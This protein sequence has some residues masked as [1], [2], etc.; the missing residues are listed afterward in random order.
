[1]VT[2]PFLR[3]RLVQCVVALELLE[4]P[5]PELARHVRRYA[6]TLGVD[7]PMVNAAPARRR[8]PARADVRRHPAQLL[9]HRGG[10]A[11]SPPRPLL[12]AAALEVRVQQP[13]RP[14]AR[15]NASGPR[16][17]TCPRARSAARSPSSTGS[18]TSRSPARAAGIGEVGAQHDFVH[19]LADYPTDA[20]GRD[21]RLRVHRR[22]DGRP[23]G[24]R[25]ARDDARAVP[26]LDDQPRRRQEGRDRPRPTRS[27]DPG[28]H[29]PVRRRAA[30]RQRLPGRRRSA[31][32]T[33]PS[34]T[35]RSTRCAS[36]FAIPP[37]EDT[38]QPGALDR[39]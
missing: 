27:S 34:P 24:V 23:E 26:E 17:P 37:R 32:T 3:R 22:L 36:E 35:S 31:S 19:V 16:S 2:D 7:E 10:E 4:D 38:S 5:T 12:A 30:P 25:A 14:A 33:S 11:A 8:R 1:M 18:T 21:R 13:R 9:L 29:R 39:P 28:R 6:R 20:R 15:S